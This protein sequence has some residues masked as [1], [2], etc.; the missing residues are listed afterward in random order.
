MLKSLS[1]KDFALVEKM[2]L[3]F[4]KGMISLTGETGAGKSILLG[5]IGLLS[6]DKPKKTAVRSGTDQAIVS[7][8]FDISYLSKVKAFL[9]E[10]GLI[11]A[12]NEDEC[13][14]RRVIRKDGRSSSFINDSAT[15]LKTIV[16][17]GEMLI[18]I[19]GQHQ[20]QNLSKKRKQFDI[21]DSFSG[22][23]D[24]RKI[25]SEYYRVWKQ[26][27]EDALKI[28]EDFEDNYNK[29][30]LLNYKKNE[31]E[32]LEIKENEVEDLEIEQQDLSSADSIISDCEE[33]VSILKDGVGGNDDVIS[34]L[35]RV[36]S[37]IENLN[38]E[39]RTK[40]ILEMLETAKINAE[41]A[42][43]SI[44]L[45]RD[46]FEVNPERLIEVEDR[47]RTLNKAAENFH[48]LP[49]Q[50]FSILPS[51]KKEIEELN[52]SEDA[53]KEAEDAVESAYQEYLEKA[54]ELSNLRM[55]GALEL[56]KSVN[57]ETIKLNLAE[58]ILK[59]DFKFSHKTKEFDCSAYGIDTVDFLIRPN[60]GQEY[61]SISVIASGGELSRL[62][63]AVQ[64]VSFKNEK[65]PT[66]IF[67]EVDTGLSGETGNVV[68][69]LLRRVGELG[70]VM[71]VTHL[72]QVAA[73][74][75]SH[76]FVSKNNVERNGEMITLSNIRELSKDERVAEVAR[77]I[78]GDI[79][80]KDT[81]QSA[82]S[83]LCD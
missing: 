13:I 66:M 23:K 25:V 73:Q 22:L 57:K 12:D 63:L 42:S 34:L 60:L 50:L 4:N 59:I 51:I 7:G 81:L 33:S 43:D 58:D 52:Y 74:G 48:C 41:E 55:K 54:K 64:V 40:D 71:C 10:R 35:G 31:L 24:K 14:I 21:L 11:D 76:Y 69:D 32:A 56:C 17:L 75:H 53:V 30:Q 68:G 36:L 47:L 46:N 28:K 79:N 16:E 8:V 80:S 72:P 9:D 2:N 44:K 6:G 65:K 38:D 67:D 83:M 29:Y 49:E 45:Y 39:E 77:M 19:H 82:K 15:N 3:D 5:A 26:K 37:N 70:Q 78:G 61:Q 27:E 20:H 1:V 18:E 62:S